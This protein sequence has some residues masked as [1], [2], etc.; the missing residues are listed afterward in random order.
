MPDRTLRDRMRET[1]ALVVIGDGVLGATQPER[2]LALWRRG[3][4]PYRR[5]MAALARRPGLTQML[6]AAQV[7]AGLWWASRQRP[8][9]RS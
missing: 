6:S 7:G 2:H 9:N 4:E 5:A 1:F 8:G 3:P